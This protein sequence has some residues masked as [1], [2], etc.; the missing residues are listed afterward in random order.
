MNKVDNLLDL[1]CVLLE[2]SMPLI[3]H[4]SILM[5]YMTDIEGLKANYTKKEL[6]ST[7]NTGITHI[8]NALYSLTNVIRNYPLDE[9]LAL[10]DQY[11]RIVKA[12]RSS[13]MVPWYKFRPVPE[14]TEHVK[15]RHTNLHLR[16]A[17]HLLRRIRKELRNKCTA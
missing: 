16:E 12:A 3:N 15:S 9:Q 4:Y 17:V 10:L 1:Y 13:I 2:L 5:P 14:W 11:D 8:L 7:L 6:K